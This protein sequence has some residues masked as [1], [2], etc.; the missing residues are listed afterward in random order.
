[1]SLDQSRISQLLVSASNGA[2][3]MVHGQEQQT[4]EEKRSRLQ[5]PELSAEK[6]G[7]LA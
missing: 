2:S 6:A 4:E 1:M 3:A 5:D 7:A